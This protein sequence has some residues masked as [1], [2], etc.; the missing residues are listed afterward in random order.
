[1]IRLIKKNN[2][3]KENDSNTKIHI[4]THDE[5]DNNGDNN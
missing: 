3:I 1:M 4:T 2:D 5:N